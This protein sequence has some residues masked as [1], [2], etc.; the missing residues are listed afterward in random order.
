MKIGRY[1]LYTIKQTDGKGDGKTHRKIG[2]CFEPCESCPMYYCDVCCGDCYELCD[3]LD[4]EPHYDITFVCYLPN[5]IKKILRK[6]LIKKQKNEN[7]NI[8]KH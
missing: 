8:S 4:K 7:K 3:L 1:E 6:R 2:V 5:F